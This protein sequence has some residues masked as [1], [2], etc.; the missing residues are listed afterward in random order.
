MWG[1][2]DFVF[3]LNRAPYEKK[4]S[5]KITLGDGGGEYLKKNPDRK[6]FSFPLDRI[7]EGEKKNDLDNRK[8]LFFLPGLPV[9]A[10]LEMPV[11]GR[12]RRTVYVGGAIH[13]LQESRAVRGPRKSSDNS[14]EP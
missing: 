7:R 3:L 1:G 13:A 4:K 10:V 12:K 5:I 8:V 11:Y 6:F 2:G 9:V 14:N